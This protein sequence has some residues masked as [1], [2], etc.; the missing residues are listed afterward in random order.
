MNAITV[1]AARELR[2]RSRLFIVAA[3][4]GVLPFLTALVPAARADRSTAVATVAGFL[5]VAYSAALALA[6]GVS[7]IGG[8]LAEKRL[9]FY[10]ARPIAPAALWFGK[11]AAALLTVAGAFAIIVLP[12]WLAARTGWGELWT[13]GGG[14]VTLATAIGC[15]LLLFLGHALSTMVR[16][17]SPWVVL[18]FILLGM[19]VLAAILLTRPLILG[20]AL[21][22]ATGLGLAL[23]GALLLTLIFGPLWQ[24]SRGRVDARRNHAA[25]S[26]AV[27]STMAVALLA[28]AGYSFWMTHPPLSAMEHLQRREQDPTGRWAY[29]AGMAKGRGM[30]YASFLVDT[31]GPRE[32]IAVP[33]WGMATFSDDGRTLAWMESE[34]LLPPGRTFRLYTRRLEPGAKAVATPLSVEGQ[35][36]WFLSDDAARVVVVRHGNA[37]VYETAT[38]RVLAVA[39]LTKNES[40]LEVMYFAGPNVLRIV[41]HAG[42]PQGM[43]LRELDVAR[44]TLVTTGRIEAD[45]PD[46][47]VSRSADGSRLFFRGSGSSYDARTGALL[48]TPAIRSRN[49]LAATMLRDGSS[50][51]T[52]DGKLYHLD[53]AGRIAAELALPAPWAMVAGEVGQGKVLLA[54]RV[55][56][57]LDQML[58][59]D[60]VARRIALTPSHVH[61]PYPGWNT[62]DLVTR[63]AEDAM[64]VAHGDNG[65]L[66]LWDV[67]TG[68]TR[69]LS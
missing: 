21:S 50:I 46:H 47:G 42:A 6:F 67:R 40:E 53:R 69:P 56:G 43:R 7:M 4:M 36:F 15:V 57:N 17:R 11:V 48:A 27:W 62:D 29:L 38:G 54:A 37:E 3:C 24:L 9:S 55:R 63:F 10:L 30:Y 35:H 13:I 18:D 8:E 12:A 45:G 23:G 51:V 25:L 28:G 32:R 65:E 22:Q 49:P 39:P 14:I 61:G 41:D 20:G 59:V 5:A 66:L 68:K 33:A 1:I 64:L 58:V 31:T 34:D 60:L 44:R 52:R 2:D 19:A 16:S 26:T